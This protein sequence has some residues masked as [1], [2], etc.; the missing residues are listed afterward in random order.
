MFIFFRKTLVFFLVTLLLS[1]I[2]PSLAMGET[3]SPFEPDIS[4]VSAILIDADTAQV[5]WSKNSKEA[6]APA[7]LTKMMTAIVVLEKADLKDQVTISEEA[8]AV[9]ESE[10]WL[11]AGEVLSVEDLLYAA[12]IFSANDAAVALAEHVAGSEDRFVQLMNEK[13]REIGASQTNFV[14]AT[15]LDA[16][17]HLST[18]YDLAL[19]ARY[20]MQ[21]ETFA[22]IVAAQM[23]T[24]PWAGHEDREIENLNPLLKDNAFIT[25]V[26]TGYTEKAGWCMAASGTREGKN[27]ISII[28]GSENPDLRGED[29]LAVLNYGFNNFEREKIIDQKVSTFLFQPSDGATPIKVAPQEDLWVLLPKDK[30][31]TVTARYMLMQDIS[32]PLSRGEKIGE[33]SLW[34]GDDLLG[35]EDLVSL[36]QISET[37]QAERGK[38]TPEQRSASLSYPDY[39]VLAAFA[40]L[41]LL[42]IL[43]LLR[44][45]LRGH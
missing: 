9:G 28:L 14:N 3:L 6:R 20:A 37:Q 10:I 41:L 30:K 22:R 26:K 24:I 12:L 16:E 31:A 29:A 2:I 34:M 19:I 25:G 39:A 15:G 44:L 40:L 43:R 8:A 1:M 7:S 42:S 33:I 4:A 13:A 17:E 11:S 35:Q 5:L 36:E 21:N 38:A 45:V 18:A 32:D 27:L 23:W